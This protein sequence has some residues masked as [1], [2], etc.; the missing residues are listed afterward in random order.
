MGVNRKL[1]EMD[2]SIKN[3]NIFSIGKEKMDNK[4]ES[5]K[6]TKKDI[7]LLNKSENHE[8]KEKEGQ[9]PLNE[10]KKQRSAVYQI[11]VENEIK[12]FTKQRVLYHEM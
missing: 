10:S 9:I 5:Q 2:S 12:V 7:L 3:N 8:K 1:D 11:T 6:L 4:Q